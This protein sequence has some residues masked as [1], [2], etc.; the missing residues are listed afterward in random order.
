[1]RVPPVRVSD[2]YKI[3]L[4]DSEAE[5]E[6]IE[7]AYRRLARK[8]HPDVSDTPE[9][10]ERMVAINGAWEELR[11]PERRAKADRARARAAAAPTPTAPAPPQ[12]PYATRPPKPSAIGT[13]AGAPTPAPGDGSLRAA[14]QPRPGESF[15]H[16]QRGV[17]VG[18]DRAGGR[19]TSTETWAGP[20]PGNAS[21]SV[22]AFGRYRGWSIG[23][24]ARHDM[25]YLEWLERSPSGRPF[26][27][28]VDVLLR[29]QGRRSPG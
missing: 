27:P 25:G 15:L 28:E 14:A 1:M 11:T 10:R 21:G 16:T 7:A 2:P 23:E 5:F 9:T 17:P 8:Y 24:I 18:H 12:P 4:V 13:Q 19:V 20:P 3:L 29:A 22:I 26:R 6:V